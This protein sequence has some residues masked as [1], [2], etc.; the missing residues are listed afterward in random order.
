MNIKRVIIFV[1]SLCVFFPLTSQ[2][3]DNLYYN[4]SNPDF[5]IKLPSA[6]NEISGITAIGEN[7]IA[8]VQD[9]NGIIFIYDISKN[10]VTNKIYFADNGDYEGIAIVDTNIYVLRSDGVIFEISDFDKKEKKIK[11]Y[12]TMIPAADNEGLCFD[13]KNNR[14]LVTCKSNPEKGKEKKDKRMIFS[15]DLTSKKLS[16]E[17]ILM[18]DVDDLYPYIDDE[19]TANKKNNKKKKSKKVQFKF[20]ISEISVNPLTD[21]YYLLS[22]V[23]NLLLILDNSGKIKSVEKLPHDIFIQAEGIT[24]LENGDMLISNEGQNKKATLLRFSRQN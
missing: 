9:E 23:D 7:I 4:L 1:I 18:F 3:Y 19:N 22:A 6:L 17:P 24:F 11:Y 13:K 10:T 20:R 8:C 5:I 16:K 15:F 14:L 12:S 2:T 21:E